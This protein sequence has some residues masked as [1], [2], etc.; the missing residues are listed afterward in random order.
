MKMRSRTDGGTHTKLEAWCVCIP[1]ITS[2]TCFPAAHR[3]GL[4]NGVSDPFRYY[5]FR[6][7]GVSAKIPPPPLTHVTSVSPRVFDTLRQPSG[8]PSFQ[9]LL[10]RSPT[11]S[12]TSAQVPPQAM[13]LGASHVRSCCR[14]NTP[15]SSTTHPQP[16]RPT[17]HNGFPRSE[18][19]KRVVY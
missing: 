7:E 12:A 16:L 8:L 11:P 17:P 9:T 6:Y 1:V 13:R 10:S 19:P 3:A 5:G 15:P 4:Q 2:K 14:C 18:I